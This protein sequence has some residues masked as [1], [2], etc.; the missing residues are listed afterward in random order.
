MPHCPSPSATG[1]LAALFDNTGSVLWVSGAGSRWNGWD[2]HDYLSGRA[3][4]IT[5]SA[6]W[7]RV[8]TAGEWTGTVRHLARE[9][10]E[11][12]VRAHLSAVTSISGPVAFHGRFSFEGSARDENLLEN[13]PVA[14]QSLDA[15]GR[16]IQVNH[17]WLETLGYQ[18]EEVVGR[19]FAEFLAPLEVLQFQERFEQFIRAGVVRGAEWT[20]VRKDGTLLDASFEGRVA[21]DPNGA[22]RRTHC[23]FIDITGRRRAM[24]A[25]REGEER[26]RKIVE[27]TDAGYFRL[28]QHGC[29]ERVNRAWLRMHGFSREDEIAGRHYSVVQVPADLE[30]SN[31][32]LR[33]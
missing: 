28:D 20:L 11:T 1:E 29:Y 7:E 21:R 10:E 17:T 9:G 22:V 19:R 27:D 12:S 4:L 6:I 8:R 24:E 15:N 14:F 31:H 25:A 32:V 26:L 18:R 2:S 3:S 16:L 23:V 30:R 33:A 5:D 13:A